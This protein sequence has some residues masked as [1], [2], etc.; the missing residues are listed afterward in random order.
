ML[1]QDFMLPLLE[2]HSNLRKSKEEL[3]VWLRSCRSHRD[4]CRMHVASLDHGNAGCTSRLA[5]IC[6]SIEIWSSP[7]IPFS[8]LGAFLHIYEDIPADYRH[9]FRWMAG[10]QPSKLMQLNLYLP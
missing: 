7:L 5:Q 4:L 8:F 10:R 1:K 6:F 9:A 3:Q 2:Y